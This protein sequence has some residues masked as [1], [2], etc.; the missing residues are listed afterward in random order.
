MGKAIDNNNFKF[1][2]S[3]KQVGIGSDGASSN[4]T[5]CVLEKKPVADHLIFTW[6]LLHKLELALK[7][8]FKG[9]ELNKKAQEQPSSEFYLFKKATLKWQLF[10]T[11]GKITGQKALCYKRGAK[12]PDGQHINLT[13]LMFIYTI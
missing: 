1:N 7:H 4:L 13:L 8:A 9:K 6:C 3:E 10:K 12:V 5:L 11:Y 2:W